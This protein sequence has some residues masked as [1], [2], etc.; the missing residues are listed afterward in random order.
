LKKVNPNF[1]F[2]SII[3][4]IMF[5]TNPSKSDHEME[6]KRAFKQE[7]KTKN[8]S[9]S[10]FEKTVEN[11][12]INLLAT[13]V[14]EILLAQAEYQNYGLFSVLWVEDSD[15]NGQSKKKWISLGIFATVF[16]QIDQNDL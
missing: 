2:I 12:M 15:E 11:A 3:A 9:Q 13:P 6:C 4:V 16:M 10:K 8:K 1:I 7:L 14:L 5:L